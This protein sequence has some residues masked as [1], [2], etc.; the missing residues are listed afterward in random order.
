MPSDLLRALPPSVEA[1]PE[2]LAA[3]PRDEALA[4]VDAI[5]RAWAEGAFGTSLFPDATSVTE[6]DRRLGRIF[7]RLPP[8]LAEAGGFEVT[9]G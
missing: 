8:A 9:A 5:Q 1:W 4:L 3:M 6:A 2:A 7:G